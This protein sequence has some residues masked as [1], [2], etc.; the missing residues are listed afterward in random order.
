MAP[1]YARTSRQTPQT[2]KEINPVEAA[3][4]GKTEVARELQTAD[5]EQVRAN[6]SHRRPNQLR[7]AQIR[8]GVHGRRRAIPISDQCVCALDPRLRDRT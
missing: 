2:E 4:K 7:H 3:E 6:I 8:F 5:A 1:S